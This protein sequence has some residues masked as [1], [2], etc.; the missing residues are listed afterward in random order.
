MRGDWLRATGLCWLLAAV[1][2]ASAEVLTWTHGDE[3]EGE[4]LGLENGRLQW[5]AADLAAPV[6]LA[7]PHLHQWRARPTGSVV[8]TE[9]MARTGRLTLQDGS[10]FAA[11]LKP[12]NSPTEN[13]QV[14][15]ALAG[16]LTLRAAAVRDWLRL[17]PAG[18]VQFAGPA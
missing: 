1:L 10:L 7:L 13:W 5:Q 3:M 18:P 11:D 8:I 16:P 9:K 14:D 4:W 2:P 12:S 15:T 17:S 6:Q